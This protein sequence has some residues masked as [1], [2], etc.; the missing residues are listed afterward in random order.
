V[1]SDVIL[2][3]HRGTIGKYWPAER[4][5]VD[6]DYRTIPFPFEE[7]ESPTF[8]TTLK[9]SLRDY[10]GFVRTWSSVKRYIEVHAESPVPLF[11]A[12]LADYWSDPDDVRT[13]TFPVISR[14][15]RVD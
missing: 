2:E 9:W 1:P 14:V 3:F 8:E 11:E 12:A 5:Y 13:V 6:E 15:G 7:I 4:R 10:L